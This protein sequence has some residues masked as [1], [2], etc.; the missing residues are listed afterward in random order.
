MTRSKLPSFRCVLSNIVDET[1]IFIMKRIKTWAV[2]LL[3][4]S[5]FHQEVYPQIDTTLSEYFPLNEGDYW[6]Y[7]IQEPP[8]LP[9]DRLWVKNFGDTVLPNGK[10]YSEIRGRYITPVTDEIPPAY[11]RL[12]DSLR[13]WIYTSDQASCPDREFIYYDLA[14]LDEGIW[15]VCRDYDPAHPYRTL[16]FTFSTYYSPLNSWFETKAFGSAWIDTVTGDT[17]RDPVGATQDRLG[18][19]IGLIRRIV[20]A[21]SPIELVAAIINGT[22]YGTPTGV[23][24]SGPPKRNPD[25]DPT[26]HTY[27]NP[28]P[29]EGIMHIELQGRWGILYRL[30]IY[31]I[32]GRRVVDVAGTDVA[33]SDIVLPVESRK[34]STGLYLLM[35]QTNST[36]FKTKF[37]VIN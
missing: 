35:I 33:A 16:L 7:F 27:P 28:V 8:P 23:E 15:P 11:Y 5:F 22:I 30:S 2:V 18:R 14:A 25:A 34:Y 3:S 31:D 36:I 10:S 6:E 21:A 32:L 1:P 4:F 20:E 17:I 19:G 37:L 24:D 12:D 9:S 13:V 29:L 26:V